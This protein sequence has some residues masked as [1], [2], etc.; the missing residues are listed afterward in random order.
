MSQS[1]TDASEQAYTA[2]SWLDQGALFIQLTTIVE[3]AASNNTPLYY[4][5]LRQ[6]NLKMYL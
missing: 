2:T 5:Q 3:N 6:G 1:C 4:G